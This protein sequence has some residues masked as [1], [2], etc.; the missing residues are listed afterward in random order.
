MQTTSPVDES[1]HKIELALGERINAL[2]SA[3]RA[4]SE[5]SA[6]HFH[7]HL[8]PA[9]F[10]IARWLYAF[11]PARPSE[12]AEAVGMDR[13]STSSLI[14]KMR[15]LG[16][17]D[18]SPAPDDRRSII[19]RL[20]PEGRQRVSATLEERGKEF[21]TRTQDWSTADLTRLVELLGRL[22]AD[23]SSETGS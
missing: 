1:R 22:T 18:S 14:G 13:S 12:V 11:G 7:P 4:L 16:L 8:Q 19:V 6:A 5:R 3:T 20:S 10:H 23:R 17:L 21:Y 9:A 15:S 2:I